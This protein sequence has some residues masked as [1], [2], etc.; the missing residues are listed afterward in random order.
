MRDQQYVLELVALGKEHGL[1][2]IGI[3]PA[4]PML[5]ARQAL[6]DR[7]AAGLHDGMQFTYRNPIRSTS[8]EQALKGA[9]SVVV[10][11]M[12]YLRVEP[13]PP[14]TRHAR[15]ARYARQDFYGSLRSSLGAICR[16]LRQDGFR[17][18]VY[19]DD[20]AIVDREIAHLAGIG[21]FGKNANLLLAGKGSWFVLG[22][23]VTDAEL[24]TATPVDDGCGSCRRC[25]DGCPTG[26]IVGPGVVDAGR[27]LAWLVQR[28]GDFPVELRAA[29]GD[30]IYGC[31]DCQEVCPPNRRR[32]AGA[33]EPGHE[34]WV[35]LVSLLDANDEELLDRHGRW[36]IPERNP[37]WLR[38]NALVALGN[39][40][41]PWDHEAVRMIDRY[42]E[43]PDEMLSR[44]ARWARGRIDERRNEASR[45]GG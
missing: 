24:P 33:T 10:A 40:A 5:R 23:V 4:T 25:L 20:N 12:S 21:W 42:L 36:Y 28:P 9:R 45:A 7:K 43:D 37:R 13:E 38:R 27:C 15:V 30:R 11:A 6:V 8:P 34:A 32:R 14:S 1:E 29:L 17:A 41:Q 16:R 44:H 31:D 35:D 39:I 2:R 18:S 22:C 26:A 3:A 19:A